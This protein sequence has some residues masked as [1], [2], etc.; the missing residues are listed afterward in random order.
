M[1]INK[2]LRVI[3][4][5]LALFSLLCLS[6]PIFSTNITDGES[7]HMV[8]KGYNMVEFSPWGSIVLITPVLLV[9][10]M[11]SKLKYNF[12]TIGIFSLL[13]LDCFALSSAYSAT[14]K[15]VLQQATGY[16]HLHMNQ[17]FYILAL[18]L[19]CVCFY[20]GCNYFSEGNKMKIENVFLKDENIKVEPVDYRTE[21]FYLCN[22]AYD[23]AKY[24]ENGDVV[25]DKSTIC[26]ATNEGYFA[27]LDDKDSD[28]Y[29]T[30]EL[31]EQD[32]AIGFI[33]G[34]MPTGIY[35]VFYEDYNFRRDLEVDI[36]PFDR[37]EKDGALVWILVDDDEDG[38]AGHVVDVQVTA[39]SLQD[40][41]VKICGESNENILGCAV[42]QGLSLVG[43]ITEYDA[44][45]HEYKCISAELLAVDLCRKI[46]EHRVL[47]KIRQQELCTKRSE[48]DF[49][50]ETCKN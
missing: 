50:N 26:F 5:V 38:A 47:E 14:Y 2:V 12:K 42:M 45:N 17:L 35:G 40:I 43:L 44:E 11:L 10:L 6:F 13:M 28:E 25:N 4:V 3:G 8:V 24:N 19:S 9:G 20:I 32:G 27:A 31:L 23:S 39:N 41:R 33:M 7:W 34:N 29:F 46:Y 22:K 18:F 48:R 1:Y 49:R 36:L 30:V 16:V 15:W 37:I 21:K